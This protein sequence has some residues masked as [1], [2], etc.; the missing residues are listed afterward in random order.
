[1]NREPNE[2]TG[3]KMIQITTREMDMLESQKGIAGWVPK[4]LPMDFPVESKVRLLGTMDRRKVYENGADTG[5]V[6]EVTINVHSIHC[7]LKGP[8]PTDKPNDFDPAKFKV[9]S[10]ANSQPS[11]L[12]S[13]LMT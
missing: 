12:P 4:Y 10:T 2:K 3:N 8:E 7:L 6:G 13:D 1:M 11:G 9:N 5:E